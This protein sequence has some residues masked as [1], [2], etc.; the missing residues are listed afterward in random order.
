MSDSE[1]QKTNLVSRIRETLTDPAARMPLV[2]FFGSLIYYAA[3]IR[4]QFTFGDGPELLTAMIRLGGAHPSGYPLFTMLGVIPSWIGI[5]SPWWL[6][7][8][9]VAAVP[10]ALCV[11]F[12]YFLLRELEAH[13]WVAALGALAYGMNTHVVYQSTRVEVYA[14]HCFL[15]TVSLWAIVR[16]F[17][18]DHLRYAY[19]ATFATCLALTNH[20]TSAFMVIPL[21]LGMLV[22]NRHQ[23]L[24]PKTIAT[25]FAIA[26]GTSLIY[27][28]LPLQAMANAG[29]RISWNDPQT[30]ERFWFHV[31]GQ[32]YQIFRNWDKI[33]PTLNKFERSLGRSFFPGVL[34]FSAL[35]LIEIAF[36]RW[37]LL[38]VMLGFQISAMI[39]IGSYSIRDIS[40]YYTG[41]YLAVVITFAIGADWIYAARFRVQDKLHDAFK[42]FL[43][44]LAVAWIGGMAWNSRANGY[45][46]AVA[47]EMSEAV[48]ADLEE[49]AIIFTSVDGHSFPMWY[50]V[51]VNHPGTKIAPVDT[52]MFQLKNKEWY[53]EFFR[54]HYPWVKWPP[55]D[56]VD[57]SQWRQWLIR[58]NPDINF[59]AMLA[60]PWRYGGSYSIN[61]GWHNKIIRGK[62]P[63]PA[64][65]SIYV[66]H[67][68]TA[69]QKVVLGN[70]YFYDTVGPYASGKEKIACI[71][72][73][74]SHPGLSG[75]WKFISP[76]GR[77]ITFKPH[78]VPKGNNQSWEYLET[79]EQEPGVW[80]CEVRNGKERPIRMSF[81]LE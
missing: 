16:F 30:L 58:E 29:D 54:T 46:E 69:R 62:A 37:K 20:L 65:Q 45:K 44:T 38:I 70:K 25:L 48:M 28:Y 17:R 7:S 15:L 63:S 53:R 21:T 49:P 13:P 71:V 35:G 19:L 33:V 26:I 12:L 52:V 32:E 9:C 66:K 5:P 14:L 79:N 56:V 39:Y 76:K 47:Q 42:W 36:R 6:V 73:W 64:E 77:V 41:L 80:T 68:F 1:D 61:R 60:H 10:G 4:V 22:A 55:N 75:D 3:L 74:T 18:T 34:V 50:Q 57:S 2:L 31:S 72:E 27:L 8:F 78:G 11:M 23:I 67:I 59:Y 24:K 43:I 51:Y 40:T 81:T